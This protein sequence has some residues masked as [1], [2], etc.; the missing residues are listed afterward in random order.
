MKNAHLP[1]IIF[2]LI[3]KTKLLAGVQELTVNSGVVIF[4]YPK[5][6]TGGCTKQA[7]GFRDSYDKITAAGYGVYGL[8]ADN[9]TPQANWRKKHD[10]QFHLI[11]DTEREALKAFGMLS[12][13]KIVRSHIVIGKGGVVEQLEIGVKPDKSS[14]IA[15]QLICGE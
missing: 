13:D 10:M 9:P 15:T 7:C 11:C 1:P 5:A 2:I 12:K 14:L 3:L 8:S 6:N 4:S